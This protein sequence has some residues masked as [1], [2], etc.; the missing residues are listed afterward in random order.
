MLRKEI[1]FASNNTHKVEEV[2]K[3]LPDN[4][5]LLSL[6]DLNWTEDIPEPFDTY[7]DNAK[8]KV[9]FVYDRTGMSCFSDDSGLAIDALDGRPGVFSAR[10]SGDKGNTKAN[11]DKVLHEM[12]GVTDRSGRF[13]SVIAYMDPLQHVTLFQGIVEGKITMKPMGTGGFGYD[14]IFIPNGFDQT[15]GQL[16]EDLK[17]KIS[18]RAVS[19]KKFLL[20]LS[21][22]M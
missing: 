2:R 4:Y 20:F 1:L 13:Y 7:E 6:H 5:H 19:M 16:P 8:A 12:K 21:Q 17:N 14:P 10:Y 9:Q 22:Q 15:F 3:L 18:H 11:I